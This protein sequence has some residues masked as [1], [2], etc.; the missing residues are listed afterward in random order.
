MTSCVPRTKLRCAVY[1]LIALLIFVILLWFENNV[2]EEFQPKPQFDVVTTPITHRSNLLGSSDLWER[3]VTDE[4]VAC[5]VYE[6]PLVPLEKRHALDRK[7]MKC[8]EPGLEP[9]IK[10]EKDVAVVNRKKALCEFQGD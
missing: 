1:I 2:D 4:T 9:W 3:V 5:R 7:P 8:S 10:M 6:L